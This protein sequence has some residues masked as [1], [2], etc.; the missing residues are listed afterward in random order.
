MAILELHMHKGNTY[1]IDQDRRSLAALSIVALCLKIFLPVITALF[2]SQAAS[3]QIPLDGKSFES[4]QGII[5]ALQLIC[6]PTG[7]TQ[8][9]SN[10]GGPSSNHQDHCDH[11]ITG[12]FVSLN[13]TSIKTG[14]SL[15]SKRLLTWHISNQ[16][17]SLI[18]QGYSLP[19]SRAPPKA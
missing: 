14:P 10:N 16:D 18:A 1:T 9:E 6:T 4:E 2:I 5:D 13:Y 3:A 7:I 19:A 17:K 8:A 12:N 15:S 11:C